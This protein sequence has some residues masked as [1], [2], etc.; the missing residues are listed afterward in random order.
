[1]L[2]GTDAQPGRMISL[3]T[4]QTQ[5]QVDFQLMNFTQPS[6]SKAFQSPKDRT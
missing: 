2:D 4:D 1:M 5:P 6:D 3:S